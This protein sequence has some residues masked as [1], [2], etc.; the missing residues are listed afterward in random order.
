VSVNVIKVHAQV[1]TNLS[2]SRLLHGYS[3][4]RAHLARGGHQE[5]TT[6][7]YVRFAPD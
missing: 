3:V 6:L 4:C 7:R 5:M 2:C 1:P